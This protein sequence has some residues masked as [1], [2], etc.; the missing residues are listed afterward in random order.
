MLCGESGSEQ[1]WKGEES[2]QTILLARRGRT[3]ECAPFS[4]G[5]EKGE[6][7]HITLRNA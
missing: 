4:K 1:A 5:N 2:S 7:A 6:K 3:M